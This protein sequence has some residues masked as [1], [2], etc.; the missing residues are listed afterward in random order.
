MLDRVRQE[1]VPQIRTSF[2]SRVMRFRRYVAA[3]MGYTWVPYYSDFEGD[4]GFGRWAYRMRKKYHDGRMRR[5]EQSVLEAAG[6]C[7]ER[8]RST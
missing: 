3:N 7:F 1:S 2:A 6:F 4:G 5:S 8:R